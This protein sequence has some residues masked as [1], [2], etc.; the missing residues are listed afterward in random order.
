MVKTIKI[1]KGLSSDVVRFR[2]IRHKYETNR[3]IKAYSLWV[4]L[5]NETESGII[6][7]YEKQLPYLLE[8]L[9]VSR[10]TFYNYLRY[11]E[12]LKLI[13]RQG[14]TIKLASYQSVID[15]LCLIDKSFIYINYDLTHEKQKIEHILNTLE[16]HENSEK[17]AKAIE[18]KISKNSI[19]MAAFNLFWF[20]RGQPNIP[21][22][23]DNLKKV[24]KILFESGAAERIYIPL[25]ELVNPEI[26]RN[27]ATIAAAHKY[28]ARRL[29]T[30]L[31]RKLKKAGL[32]GIYKGDN[33]TCFYD[34]NSQEG[35]QRG[36]NPNAFCF[37][38]S[39]DKTKVWH[40]PHSI[41]IN[42]FLFSKN[43]QIQETTTLKTA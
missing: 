17:Q 36:K 38:N 34:K 21:F 33:P 24:Q 43:N 29:V 37:Y 15:D 10:A 13:E 1:L 5:K 40:K 4:L 3:A 27:S 8:L 7:H 25:M 31:K 2:A 23:L 11:A 12:Q 28:K 9:K 26:F 35:I 16:F 30:Y 6:H 32:I 20:G 22:N 39:K 14:G 41:I 19:I 18:V 42:P